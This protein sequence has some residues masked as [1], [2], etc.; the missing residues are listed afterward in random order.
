MKK[1]IYRAQVCSYSG[2]IE[3]ILQPLKPPDF[4]LGLEH[5]AE[6]KNEHLEI[7]IST[8]AEV[9]GNPALTWIPILQVQISLC[10]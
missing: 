9:L 7:G 3:I 10:I 1:N 8:G 2:N 5:N 4:R 6:N